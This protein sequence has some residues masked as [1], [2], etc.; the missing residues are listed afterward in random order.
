MQNKISKPSF[1][2]SASHLGQCPQAQNIEIVCLGRSNVGKSSFINFFLGKKGLAKSSSVPGKTRLI[3]FYE[4]FYIEGGEEIPF[5]IVDLPGFG[6]AKVS[7]DQKR[8]W[9]KN[10]VEFLERRRSIKLFLH[11]IDSRHLDLKIDT[12]LRGFLKALCKGDQKVLE[13]FTKADK[14]KSQEK[15]AL[16]SSGKHLVSTLPNES[17]ITT[18]D[19][20]QKHIINSAL[21]REDEI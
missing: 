13:I 17:K 14:L 10:L 8:T 9:E 2:L 21:G 6:Y 20:L 3:N 18:L 7:K 15:T 19:R 16:L 12:E 4:A 11:L 1:L 5:G